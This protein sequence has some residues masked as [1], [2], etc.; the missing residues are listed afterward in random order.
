MTDA[1]NRH[2]S[3]GQVEVLQELASCEGADIWSYM[4]ARICRELEKA[5]LVSVVPAKNAPANGALRQPY[6]GVQITDDGR[7]ILARIDGGAAH[8]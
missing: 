5:G 2:P 8:E 4:D 1:I 3:K 7:A 6:F